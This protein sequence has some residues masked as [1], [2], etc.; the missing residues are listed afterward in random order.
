MLKMSNCAQRDMTILPKQNSTMQVW[1]WHLSLSA[2]LSCFHTP[3]SSV[4][5]CLKT[6]AAEPAVMQGFLNILP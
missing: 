5:H 4:I 6:R 2:A 1:L 3:F